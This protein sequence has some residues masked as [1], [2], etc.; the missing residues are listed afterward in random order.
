MREED[1]GIVFGLKYL[2]KNV[3]DELI[4]VDGVDVK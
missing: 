1:K 2:N 3:L 4:V